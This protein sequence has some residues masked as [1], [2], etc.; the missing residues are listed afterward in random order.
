MQQQQHFPPH[1]TFLSTSPS[2]SSSSA[3]CL[4]KIPHS[5]LTTPAA[6]SSHSLPLPS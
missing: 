4:M 6:S 5:F 2:S 1:F 3:R